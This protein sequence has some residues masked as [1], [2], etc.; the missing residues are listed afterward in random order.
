MFVAPLFA[1]AIKTFNYTLPTFSKNLHEIG[2]ELNSPSHRL[3]RFP[4][5][6]RGLKRTTISVEW[7]TRERV[8]VD[9][10]SICFLR[11]TGRVPG[12]VLDLRRTQWALWP[13]E[14][15]PRQISLSVGRD[16]CAHNRIQFLKFERKRMFASY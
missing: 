3:E 14:E 1:C 7:T 9:G 10:V 4:T 12:E 11:F 2:S 6:N 5:S 16:M 8:W 15:D 13:E